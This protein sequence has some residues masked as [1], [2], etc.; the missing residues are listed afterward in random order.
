M[1]LKDRIAIVTGAG[2]GI[3]RA[4]ARA[5]ALEGANVIVADLSA[6]KGGET[7]AFIAAEGGRASALATDVTDDAQLAELIARTVRDFGRLDILHSHAGIQVEGTLEQVDPSG[8]TASWELNVR[9]HFMAARLAM[10]QMREQG[11]GSII[12]TSSN[13]GVFYDREML[14]YATTKHA[15]IAMVRQI[16]IDYGRYN[17]RINALC[18]GWVD[19]PFNEPFIRQMGG[20]QAIENYVKEKIPLGR[21]ARPEE[22]AEAIVFLASDRSSFMTGHAL[23]VDGGEAIA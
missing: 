1:I 13:S 6:E 5:L 11:G 2:S 17:V 16:A 4:G 12:V 15:V 21:W 18:P 7:V 23:V 20:R 10:P 3:G 8:L 19:T 14:A 22:I 9:A